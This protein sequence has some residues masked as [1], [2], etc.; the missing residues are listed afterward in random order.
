MAPEVALGKPYNETID[1]YSFGL[2]LYQ[3][4]ALETPFEGLTIKSFPKIVFEK[5]ARPIPDP[6]WPVEI[7]TLMHRCWTAKISDRPSMAKV[8]KVLLKEIN[9]HADQAA[10]HNMKEPQ[11]PKTP[12]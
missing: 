5:G 10:H 6:K 7:S 9:A 4:L 12:C 2:L 1:V 11:K 3:I 8:E